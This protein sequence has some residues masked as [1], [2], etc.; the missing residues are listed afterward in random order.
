M[1]NGFN[2]GAG[3]T[4]VTGAGRRLQRPM[5]YKMTYPRKHLEI[6]QLRA[7][8]PEMRYKIS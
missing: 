8:F 3:K 7:L 6:R 1:S 2:S 4:Q 5:R